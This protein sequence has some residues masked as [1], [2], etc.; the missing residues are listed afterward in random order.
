MKKQL[1]VAGLM[2][3][4]TW[5]CGQEPEPV[6]AF[7]ELI[8]CIEMPEPGFS[9]LEEVQFRSC[10]QN[11]VYW[12]WSFGDGNA[13]T[14][15]HP[16]HTYEKGGTYTV[17]LTVDDGEIE[18]EISQTVEVSEALIFYH[19][20]QTMTHDSVWVEGIHIVKGLIAVSGAS[21]TIEPG[22]IVKFEH[23][24]DKRIE[25]GMKGSGP[26][27]I[28]A[29]GTAELPILFTTANTDAYWQSWG[30]IAIGPEASQVSSLAYATFEYGGQ[31]YE[32]NR[33]AA[34]I[35]L[36][37]GTVKMENCVIRKPFNKHGIYLS[38]NSAF[39][40]FSGNTIDL[41]PESEYVLYIDTDNL[42]SI[43]T[44]NSFTGKGIELSHTNIT[45][46]VT[47]QPFEVPYYARALRVGNLTENTLTIEEGTS[48]YFLGGGGIMSTLTSG[49]SA[50]LI[51][52]GTAG[53]PVKLMAAEGTYWYGITLDGTFNPESFLDYVEISGTQ[54]TSAAWGGTVEVKN[55]TLNM[56]NCHVQG[57][58]SYAIE[59]DESAVFG[60]FENNTLEKHESYTIYAHG[61][62]LNNFPVNNTFGSPED[63]KTGIYINA[64]NVNTATYNISQ[65]VTITNAGAPYF[66][67]EKVTLGNLN[68]PAA[69]PTLTV[70][71]GAALR[72]FEGDGL[73]IAVEEDGIWP[74]DLDATLLMNGTAEKP[75]SVGSASGAADWDG[76][77]FMPATNSASSMNFTVVENGQNQNVRIEY[78]EGTSGTGYPRIANSVFRNAVE[79]PIYVVKGATPVIED[80]NTYEGNGQDIVFYEN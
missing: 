51:I 76:I 79:Y 47:M 52:R 4:L 14:D 44:G 62:H 71:A 27:S 13:S 58:M 50:K 78:E 16:T 11:A 56:T 8:A 19:E 49:A 54:A 61:S 32:D 48:I 80:T 55:T 45:S 35:E 3:A 43:G 21:L 18:K 40:A 64:R 66:F 69:G 72:F 30:A 17:T 67:A 22:A 31:R 42:P 23:G 36:L 41:D 53:N 57:A 1:C 74:A 59:M 28:I 75:I 65:D 63:L 26:S 5:G 2:A 12:Y 33:P 39:T 70:E 34:P 25:V 10:S 38:D 37:D 73:Y 9:A 29:E 7:D 15:E 77:H 6:P 68:S 20:A 60:R 46:N 24:G